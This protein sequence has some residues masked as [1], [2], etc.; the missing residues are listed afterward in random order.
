MFI[1]PI[2]EVRILFYEFA[3]LY[4]IVRYTF[5]GL[6]PCVHVLR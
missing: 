4:S 5:I 3:C 6:D 1:T 2:P